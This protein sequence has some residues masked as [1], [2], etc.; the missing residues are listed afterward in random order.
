[1][2]QRSNKLLYA[3][4]DELRAGRIA[5]R[6]FEIEPSRIAELLPETFI[7]ERVNRTE[8]RFRLA[9]TRVCDWF[10]REFRGTNFLDYWNDED[11]SRLES[12]VISVAKTGAVLVADVEAAYPDDERATF[13]LLLLPLLHTGARIDRFM[14]VVANHSAID[15]SVLGATA[16]V[17]VLQT[18]LHGPPRGEVSSLNDCVE[19]PRDAV[20]HPHLRNARIVRQDRRSFRVYDGG[21]SGQPKDT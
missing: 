8:F 4:W 12:D 2:R 9:G 7:L 10:G 16:Q 6:R 11:R 1:M 15:H 18:H 5:P 3:Y 19:G 20:F 17:S 21:L 14:G 13:E